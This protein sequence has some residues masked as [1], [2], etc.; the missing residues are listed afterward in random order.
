LAIIPIVYTIAT[1]FLH[2]VLFYFREWF[3]NYFVASTTKDDQLHIRMKPDVKESLQILAESRGLTMSS[4]VHSLIVQAIRAEKLTDP[5]LFAGSEPRANEKRK[6]QNI[7]VRKTITVPVRG[8][9][10]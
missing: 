5:S 8:K 7:P 3:M 9:V 4:F 2:D 1:P 6:A 10:S